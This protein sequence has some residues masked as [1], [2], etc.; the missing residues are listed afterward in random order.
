MFPS[1]YLNQIL[2]DAHRSDLLKQMNPHASAGSPTFAHARAAVARL[3][4]HI[5]RSA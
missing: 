4:G 5:G 2:D 3:I 1:P